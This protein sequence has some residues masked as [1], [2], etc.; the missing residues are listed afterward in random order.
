MWGVYLHECDEQ[1]ESIGCPSNLL[2]EEP[3]QESE[4]PILGGTAEKNIHTDTKK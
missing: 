3:G 1:E 2:I 4:N